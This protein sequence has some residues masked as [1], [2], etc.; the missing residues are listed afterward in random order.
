MPSHFG[1]DPQRLLL[2]TGVVV[3]SAVLLLRI[4]PP[5]AVALLSF[6]LGAMFFILIQLSR[7]AIRR[8]RQHDP[9]EFGTRVAARLA[10]A[11]A[12][13]AR[14]REE[15]DGIMRSIRTL[16]E[17]LDASK[18][19]SEADR[20]RADGLVR[21]LDAEFSLRNAKAAFFSDCAGRLEE[22]LGRHRLLESMQARR[23]ELDALRANNFDDESAVEEARYHLE[24]DNI[25]LDTIMELSR[26]IGDSSHVQQ[27]E[28]LR[29]RLD[30]LRE[31]LNG[32]T[33]SVRK[34]L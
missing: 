1:S 9:D 22:L 31:A 17:D 4:H 21:E 13:E 7:E 12:S 28:D 8:K 24:Q 25:E 2:L 32:A 26:E 20:E 10:E 14:F 6:S 18:Q 16:R 5:L 15:S 33:N 29:R 27:A 30:K 3:V 34:K 19:V 11:R 23:R